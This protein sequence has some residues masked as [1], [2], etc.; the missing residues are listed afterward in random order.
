MITADRRG[1]DAA[2]SNRLLCNRAPIATQLVCVPPAAWCG[3]E[4]T[5]ALNRTHLPLHAKA[6]N[7][8][9]ELWVF[10]NEFEVRIAQSELG[11]VAVVTV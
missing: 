6:S 8:Q 1:C 3:C 4:G 5:L 7:A 9:P 10:P 11:A 2:T